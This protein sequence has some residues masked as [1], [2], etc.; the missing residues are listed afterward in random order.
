MVNHWQRSFTWNIEFRIIRMVR[1]QLV[2]H[3]D[4]LPILGKS[5]AVGRDI[6]DVF[7]D[8]TST[9][10]SSAMLICILPQ[11]LDQLRS[12]T[13]N[14]FVLNMNKGHHLQLMCHALLIQN[15]KQFSIMS[16]TPNQLLARR[17]W[18]NY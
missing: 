11:F 18:M 2:M 15:F 14:R 16:A 17:R 6:S 3:L 4:V 13:S 1:S 7:E 5:G 9:S 10:S 12:I 8:T